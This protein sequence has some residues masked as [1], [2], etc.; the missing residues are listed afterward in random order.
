M[1]VCGF[2][3]VRN[4]VKFDYPVRESILSVLPLCDEFI[5]AAG[6]SEDRTRELIA[7]I[8]PAKIRIIDTVWDE[9][10]RKGGQVLAAETDK[11]L[12]AVPPGFDWAFYLQADEVVH[13]TH[14]AAIRRGM[15]RWK[16]DPRVE[17]LLFN[18]L[19][20]FG[21]YDYIASTRDWYRREVR[22]IRPGAN[23]HSYRDAQGF[24]KDGRKLRVK[25]LEASIYHYGWVKPPVLQQAKQ[26]SFHRHWHDDQ[27]VSKN[28]GQAEAF[29]YHTVK[30]LSRFTGSHPQSIKER[31]AAK[32]WEF[33]PDPES[34]SLNFPERMLA[35]TEKL[36]GWRPGEYRNYKI[37]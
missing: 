21:S 15:E 37:I 1:K 24:R 3:F 32:N 23:I 10:M 22:I 28:V 6:N 7:S 35:W 17:G 31:L 11:A 2:T 4:A 9:G 26:E 36:T 29:D 34:N 33:A 18:Y 25:P 30:G 27:W 19:H 14:H 16:D 13:E 20:F 12:E 8:D 5:V